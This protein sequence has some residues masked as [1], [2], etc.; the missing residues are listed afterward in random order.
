MAAVG[1]FM[2]IVIPVDR[3]LFPAGETGTA[4][5]LPAEAG[6]PAGFRI[7]SAARLIDF[8]VVAIVAFAIQVIA[9]LLPTSIAAISGVVDLAVLVWALAFSPGKRALGLRILRPDGSRVGFGRRICRSLAFPFLSIGFLMI[10]IRRDKRGLHDLIC[11]TIVVRRQCSEV[12]DPPA[13]CP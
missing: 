11:G 7:R 9:G 12:D 13:R 8:V 5:S 4:L 2:S 6:A 3:D 10:A 1:A